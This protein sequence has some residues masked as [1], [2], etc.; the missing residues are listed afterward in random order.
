LA[1]KEVVM[2][3][4]VRW[5]FVLAVIGALAVL[6]ACSPPEDAPLTPES[7][8]QYRFK[9]EAVDAY[10]FFW[11]GC[12][13]GHLDVFASNGVQKFSGGRPVTFSQAVVY[14]SSY[15]Y[16]TDSYRFGFGYADLDKGEFSVDN[17]LNAARL[18]KTF[19]MEDYYAGGF[20]LG[21][22]IL[23]TGEGVVIRVKESGQDD[24]D[25]Y[26][27]KY[28]FN[29]TQRNAMVEGSASLDGSSLNL[30]GH[31][32]LYQ[33]Q[34]GVMYITQENKLPPS[35]QYFY[36][37]PQFIA[38]GES[39][40]LHWSAD[41]KRTLVNIEPDV[42]PVAPEGSVTVSPAETTTYVLTATNR[43]GSVSHAATVYVVIPD[44]DEDDR[45]EDATAITLDFFSPELRI[46][47]GDMDWFRFTLAEP[48]AMTV[49]ADIEASV[50]GSTLDSVLG[51]FDDLLNPLAI[52]DDWDSLDSYL[53]L[54][55]EPG[56]YYLAVSGFPDFGFVGDH[57]QHGFYYLSVTATP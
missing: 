1:V 9:G 11:N 20:E 26:R 33:T 54:T 42:G 10:F 28:R 3:T 4:I 27:F 30:S 25:G 35:I 48:T 8:S 46:A 45:P 5:S 19:L 50:L 6:A 22:D 47:P 2:A 38:P 14:L 7:V 17:K 16:C 34:Q 52:N 44:P 31:G 53:E 49:T 24:G 18:T 15:D 36:A 57:F 12:L 39:A 43:N 13:S 32:R 40:T 21:L 41:G 51:L 23:W 29:G 37:E 56:T 55:L